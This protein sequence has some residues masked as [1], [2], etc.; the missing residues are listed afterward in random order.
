[1][2]P[3][4]L[5]FLHVI[6]GIVLDWAYPINFGHAWGWLGLVLLAAC[7]LI[8]AWAKRL[9]EKAGTNVPPNQPTLAIVKTGPYRF[10]RNPMYLSFML[11]FAGLSFLADA[12][13]MLLL[14][15]ALFYF[16]DRRV[17]VPEEK[18]LTEKFGSVYTD[19]AAQVRR[20]I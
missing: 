10:T 18:Y 2:L 7:F 19:Y 1:M 4:V 8:I 16:L 5:V 20:W 15:G 13:A 3:P 9:F 12:P 14:G 17:I 11:G 6:A